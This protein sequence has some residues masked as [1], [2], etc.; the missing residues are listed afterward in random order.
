MDG[1]RFTNWTDYAWLLIVGLASS[2]YCA[3]EANR[4]G[5][6]FDEPL[7]VRCGLE[8]WRTGSTYELMR[9]GTMPLPV[10]VAALP[11]AIWERWRGMP[12]DADADLGRILPVAHLGTLAF[13]WLL[14]AYGWL[15]AGRIGGALGGP[16]GCDVARRGTESARSRRPGHDRPCAHR[17]LARLLLSLLDRAQR[18]LAETRRDT[19]DFLRS[20][21]WPRRRRSFSSPFAW[22]QSNLNGSG[23]NRPHPTSRHELRN[24]FGACSASQLA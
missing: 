3:A 17:G 16:L 20:P 14:L 4:L 12:F 7:Y 2:L 19:R 5:P 18:R 8:R 11:I 23:R 6:T 10:D 24:R 9:V 13:W 1:K 21:C 22:L 15:I